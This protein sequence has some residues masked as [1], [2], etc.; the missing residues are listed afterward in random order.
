MKRRYDVLLEVRQT[1]HAIVE[2]ESPHEAVKLAL[3]EERDGLKPTQVAEL[4][5]DGEHG[6]GWTVDGACE[7]CARPLLEGDETWSDEEGVTVGECCA[8]DED[9]GCTDPVDAAVGPEPTDYE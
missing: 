1:R 9:D 3:A 2:A 5:A 4:E 6:E 8:P 7:G